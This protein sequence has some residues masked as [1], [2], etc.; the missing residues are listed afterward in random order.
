M[1]RSSVDVEEALLADIE[2]VG[3]KRFALL[4]RD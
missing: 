4:R 3:V 1:T 2:Q